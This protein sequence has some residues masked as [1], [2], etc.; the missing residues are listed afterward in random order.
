MTK[1]YSNWKNIKGK[2]PRW[3]RNQHRK[4]LIYK[5]LCDLAC[6]ISA[7]HMNAEICGEQI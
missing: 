2:R 1:Y 7:S 5:V 4:Y 6:Q 3:Y